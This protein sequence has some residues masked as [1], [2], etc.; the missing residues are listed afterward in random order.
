MT[1]EALVRRLKDGVRYQLLGFDLN[2]GA[3][4]MFDMAEEIIG[5]K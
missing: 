5:T 1:E 2:L 4:E 3:E